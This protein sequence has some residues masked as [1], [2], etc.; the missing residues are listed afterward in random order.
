MTVGVSAACA[1]ACHGLSTTSSQPAP[2][3]PPPAGMGQEVRDGHMA[4]VVR[5]V[6]RVPSIHRTSGLGPDD[7]YQSKGEY[8]VVHMTIS[9]TDAPDLHYNPV[10]DPPQTVKYQAGDQ[11]LEVG[12]QTITPDT[13]AAYAVGN[14][15]VLVDA[16]QSAEVILPFD[17][18]VG[19]P[20]GVL[21][22]HDSAFSGGARI[23]L[24]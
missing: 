8:I 6:E 16:G 15:I 14:S 21:E 2:P 17:V 4:F 19:T 12:G 1:V 18:P 22:V 5:S 3:K 20:M 23:A 11:T 10:T 13:S 7:V 9:N 24:Q